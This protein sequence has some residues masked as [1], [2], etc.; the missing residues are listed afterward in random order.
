M[1]MLRYVFLLSIQKQQVYSESTTHNIFS[2]SQAV[3]YKLIF[4]TFKKRR[5]ALSEISNV[6]QETIIPQDTETNIKL[7]KEIKERN[8]YN[9]LFRAIQEKKPEI[10]KRDQFSIPFILYFCTK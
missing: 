4:Y 10:T 6:G 1:N 3:W 7:L 2:L 5:K 8:K 9:F